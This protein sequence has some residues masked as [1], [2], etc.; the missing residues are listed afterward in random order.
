MNL[1]KTLKEMRDLGNT[2][3]IVE[4]DE[5]IMRSADHILDLGP[6]A[7]EHGGKLVA[8]GEI[9]DI[10]KCQE[11]VT[12]AYLSGKRKIDLPK[13]R[14]LGNGQ[15]LTVRGARE[16]NLNNIDV[17]FPLGKLICVTGVSGSGKSSLVYDILYKNMSQ[18]LYLTHDRP[19]D[20]DDLEGVLQIDKV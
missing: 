9:S 18:L 7:G 5:S 10:I 1:I 20:C 2:V 3:L 16:N 4:H 14:R 17:P 19:G 15:S 13:Q 12:G 11:S 6:G 8:Q